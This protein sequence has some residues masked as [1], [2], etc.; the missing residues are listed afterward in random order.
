MKRSFLSLLLLSF[1]LLTSFAGQRKIL[2]EMFSN[3][4]CSICAGQHFSVKSYITSSANANNVAFIYY[5]IPYPYS[6]DQLYLD[7]MSEN[8]VRNSYYGGAS[9]TPRFYFDGTAQGGGFSSSALDSRI[10]V[11]SPLE[12]S[13]GGMRSASSVTVQATVRRTGTI[14]QTDLIIHVVVVESGL[15]GGRNGVTPQD[16]VMRKMLTGTAGQSFPLNPDETKTHSSTFDL[17]SSW[18]A[19][20]VGIVVFV[21]STSTREVFQSEYIPVSS[22]SITGIESAND[23]PR[24]FALEQNYPNPFNPAT[25]I[26]FTI[27]EAEFVTLKIFDL[28]GREVATLLNQQMSNGI[29]TT[30]WD[31][32]GFVSGTYF[33]TLKTGHFSQTRKLILLK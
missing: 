29:Y 6:D 22:M 11:S 21:Q 28:L 10:A 18:N 33:Y 9:S 26:R 16:F 15:P 8:N 14:A 30:T 1:S 2:V 31:A 13:L 32:R 5:H 3:S 12:I 7:N 23:G 17:S 24:T 27:P 19:S 20:N 25:T 4:H